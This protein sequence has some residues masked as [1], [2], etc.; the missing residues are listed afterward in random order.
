M[1]RLSR[2]ERGSERFVQWNESVT[3]DVDITNLIG[4]GSTIFEKRKKPTR[5]EK[6]IVSSAV[7]PGFKDAGHRARSGVAM[8]DT[9]IGTSFETPAAALKTPPPPQFKPPRRTPNTRSSSDTLRHFGTPSNGAV[10]TPAHSESE[11][12]Q[13]YDDT[14]AP[15]PTGDQK[16]R[17]GR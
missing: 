16:A 10:Q 7:V 3:E 8:G 2:S 11:E 4:P 14:S 12:E 17:I 5:N 6:S 9:R 1:G 15:P 13:D